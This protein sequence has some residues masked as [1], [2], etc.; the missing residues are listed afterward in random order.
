MIFK[1]GTRVEECGWCSCG[2]E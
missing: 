2:M 1:N